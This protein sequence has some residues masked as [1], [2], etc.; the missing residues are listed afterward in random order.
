MVKVINVVVFMFQNTSEGYSPNVKKD[1]KKFGLLKKRSN[2][3]SSVDLASSSPND[4]LLPSMASM[5]FKK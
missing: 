5:Q 4:N 1:R 2:K 3:G